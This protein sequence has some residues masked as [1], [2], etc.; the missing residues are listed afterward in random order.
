MPDGVTLPDDLQAL[1]DAAIASGD[2]AD[3]EAVL[4]E[5]LEAWQANRQASADGV[6]TVRRL[7]Q[8]GLQS[9]EPREADAVFDRLRARFGTVPSE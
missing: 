4:R 7:W 9:G 6:A 5:A 1:I 8:E 2:Y 3:E